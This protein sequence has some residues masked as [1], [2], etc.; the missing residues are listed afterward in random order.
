MSLIWYKHYETPSLPLS[1]SL[2]WNFIVILNIISLPPYLISLQLKCSS[3]TLGMPFPSPPPPCHS[4]AEFGLQLRQRPVLRA[5]KGEKGGAEKISYVCEFII[6]HFNGRYCSSQMPGSAS[7]SE[8]PREAEK[9]REGEGER[10]A[11]S[12]CVC[13]CVRAFIE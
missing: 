7:A 12:A 2:F 9:E 13:V 11:E 3:N 10:D 8:T 4:T 1:V 5:D 6:K